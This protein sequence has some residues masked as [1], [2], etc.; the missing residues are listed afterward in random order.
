MNAYLED[1]ITNSDGRYLTEQERH[2]ILDYTNSLP[3]RFQ[4]SADVEANEEEIA[5]ATIE[6]MKRQYP[7][8][9][10]LHGSAWE[11]GFRD[12]QLILRYTAQ[13]MVCND[14]TMQADKLLVWFGTILGSFGITPQFNR[15]TY[16]TLKEECRS[17]LS[18]DTF[19]LMEPFLQ[20]NI[21][22][23][24]SIPEPYAPAV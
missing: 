2:T 23:L 16:S 11:K 20:K 7:N 22:V 17:R 10:R 1:L 19:R 13:A 8:F 24:S 9:G 6:K 12:M 4:A 14:E 5:R 3:A 21:D 18:S 15:D